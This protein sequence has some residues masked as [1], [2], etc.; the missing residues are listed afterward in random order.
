VKSITIEESD[1]E[2]SIVTPD[3]RLRFRW[4]GDRWTHAID[5]RPGPWTTLASAI[6]RADHWTPVP[7]YQELHFQGEGEEILALG[8]GRDGAHH[9]SA[10]FRV[11]Y[12]ARRV[13]HDDL[14][15]VA[16]TSLSR[17][18]IDVAD[19]CRAESDRPEARYSVHSPPV[20]SRLGESS[21]GEESFHAWEAAIRNSCD[22]FVSALSEPAD[23]R[24]LALDRGGD[25]WSVRVTPVNKV[26]AGTNRFAYA[27]GHS[28]MSTFEKTTAA[29]LE[30]PWTMTMQPGE[31]SA[32]PW[33]L[34]RSS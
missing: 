10:S 21:E 32:P 33:S 17:V 18:E 22:V 34:R 31:L 27:W 24:V 20:R 13:Y 25:G 23:T 2:R 1:D 12:T 7:T 6:E 5:I 19:R 15:I 11:S 4:L 14:R 29:D 16:D 28:R 9:F 3:L 26:V 30:R 8:V